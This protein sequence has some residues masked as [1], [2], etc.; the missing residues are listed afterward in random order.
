MPVAAALGINQEEEAAAT[1]ADNVHPSLSSRQAGAL[2]TRAVSKM[3]ILLALS[4]IG[5]LLVLVII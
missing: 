4:H 2:L 1:P 5:V 3:H